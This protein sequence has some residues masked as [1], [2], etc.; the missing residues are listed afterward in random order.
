MKNKE[1]FYDTK[2]ANIAALIKDTEVPINQQIL[3]LQS[4]KSR[5]P[6]RIPLT[7]LIT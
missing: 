3:R 1:V 5:H 2:T 6:I 4:Y 7:K